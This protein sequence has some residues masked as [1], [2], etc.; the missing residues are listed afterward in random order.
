[1][2][3]ARRSNAA[4]SGP[5]AG[6][7]SARHLDS[8]RPPSSRTLLREDSPSAYRL[9]W[10]AVALTA[11]RGSSDPRGAADAGSCAPPRALQRSQAHNPSPPT[12]GAPPTPGRVPH[13]GP[14]S[15][16]KHTTPAPRPQG[17]RRRRVVCPTPGP[18]AV[19]GTRPTPAGAATA[20]GGGT[21]RGGGD[22]KAP[23]A[24]GRARRPLLPSGPG[25][26]ERDAATRGVGTSVGEPRA[27][28][29]RGGLRP[30]RRPGQRTPPRFGEASGR[31]V[32]SCAEDSPSGLWRSLG[33]RVGLTALRGSNPL[34][35]A[36]GKS[37]LT[38][39]FLVQV[40]ALSRPMC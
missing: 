28:L 1:M 33:K 30:A 5:P 40:R 2:S 3:P 21:S 24:P 15:G 19:S 20:R 10:K 13:P 11:L 22:E 26:V 14:Y 7:G 36:S 6:R 37:S 12:P 8:V 31:P 4:V 25:G 16:L 17:R 23:R 18:T 9:A 39:A 29:Q 35:S 34:S 32:R 27:P 38:W